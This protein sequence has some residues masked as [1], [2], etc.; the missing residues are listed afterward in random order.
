MV[1]DGLLGVAAAEHRRR[2]RRGR[3]AHPGDGARPAAVQGAQAAEAEINGN[4]FQGIS[5]R[6]QDRMNTN[7]DTTAALAAKT[8]RACGIVKPLSRF[9][10][11]RAYLSAECRSCKDARLAA[12][13]KTRP[14]KYN[15]G[16]TDYQRYR[17][18]NRDKVRERNRRYVRTKAKVRDPLKE[19][20]RHAVRHE[21]V[22]GRIIRPVICP[23]CGLAGKIH[24]HHHNGYSNPF[25]FEWLCSIC[26]GKEH[27][28]A[29]S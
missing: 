23:S 13:L 7:G 24:A 18:R 10:K 17:D 27:R 2:A 9:V 1:P 22:K 4:P 15:D 14:Q 16:L 12:G 19:R 25:D 3:G 21:V 26:H 5:K 11:S 28:K 8:C 29:I 20:A 6:Q